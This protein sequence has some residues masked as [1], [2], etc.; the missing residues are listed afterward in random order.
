[1]SVRVNC[2]VKVVLEG[3]WN[4]EAIGRLNSATKWWAQV[5][6]NADFFER[7]EFWQE[8]VTLGP[9]T[10]Y[11]DEIALDELILV[12]LSGEGEYTGGDSY[13]LKNRKGF[14]EAV[15]NGLLADMHKG[16]LSIVFNTGE[17]DEDEPEYTQFRKYTVTSEGDDFWMHIKSRV[18]KDEEL[19]H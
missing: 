12:A 13:A 6:E 3:G 18:Q 5:A 11:T 15:H 2:K 19:M 16:G 17:A 9:F 10:T 14:D 1:M 4:A 7:L 8:G